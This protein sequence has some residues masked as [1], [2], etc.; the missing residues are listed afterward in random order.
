MQQLYPRPASLPAEEL[1][2]DL[3]LPRPDG[4]PFVYVNMVSSVDGAATLEGTS[5][6]L[7]GDGDRMAF[8]RLREWADVVLVGAGT[9]RAEDYGPVRL[10][11]DARDRRSR[12]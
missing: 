2:L 4:R 3:D 1:Y 5:G 11:D 12:Y 7:G 10:G 8:R 9:I 6:A